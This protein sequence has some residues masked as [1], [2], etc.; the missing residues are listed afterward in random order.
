VPAT[1]IVLHTN[2]VHSPH[3]LSIAP[4]RARRPPEKKLKGPRRLYGRS[5]TDTSLQAPSLQAIQANM[6]SKP[7][8]SKSASKKAKAAKAAS[9][10]LNRIANIK[11]SANQRTADAALAGDVEGLVFGR[12]TKHLGNGEVRV[13]CTDLLE[14]RAIIPG[15]LSNKRA[16]PIMVDDL[17]GLGRREFESRAAHSGSTEDIA[18]GEVFDI[19]VVFDRR[20]AARLVKRG[21]IPGWMI[22][23]ETVEDIAA[24]AARHA[25][26]GGAGDDLGDGF[27]FD[28]EGAALE[29]AAGSDL[30]DSD[31]DE[32]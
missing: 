8:I 10:P 5:S 15:R 20:S 9:R 17:V 4:T 13:L 2:S 31:I 24:K 25:A 21:I 6:S 27:E 30:D 14:H 12:V 16:T 28:Y 11:H 7:S 22:T 3:E 29:D 19:S 1:T 32:I 18:A 26:F 23:S